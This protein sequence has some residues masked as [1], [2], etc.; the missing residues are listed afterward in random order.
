MANL[1]RVDVV[2]Y[3]DILQGVGNHN[4]VPGR[5]R[6]RLLRRRCR[7]TKRSQGRSDVRRRSAVRRCRR[8][9]GSVLM[10]GGIG[11]YGRLF[12]WIVGKVHPL[13]RLGV[14]SGGARGAV[15]GL[16]AGRSGGFRC[17]P[18]R[19]TPEASGSCWSW[20]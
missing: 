8:I 10:V 9:R 16:A 19:R 3:T 7:C 17:S 12:S 13:G 11:R 18:T 15:P 4:S 1:P 14:T 20:S 2:L 5:T 6:S